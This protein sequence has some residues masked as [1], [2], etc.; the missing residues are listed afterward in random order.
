MPGSAEP[1][2][3]AA[4]TA[5]VTILANEHRLTGLAQLAFP[6]DQV[7]ALAEHGHRHVRGGKGQAA[8]GADRGPGRSTTGSG[9]T[10]VLLGGDDLV[11]AG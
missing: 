10:V 2:G 11:T 7:C 5:G 4:A 6:A 1:I 3:V 8:V 9:P